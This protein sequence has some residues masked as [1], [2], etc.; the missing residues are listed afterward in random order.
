[1]LK[2]DAVPFE[3][4]PLISKFFKASS[5]GTDFNAD[6]I[7]YSLKSEHIFND[8]LRWEKINYG[9]EKCAAKYSDTS[10]KATKNA[11]EDLRNSKE[12]IEMELQR[13]AVML[14]NDGG[15]KVKNTI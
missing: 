7:L 6:D 2:L 10:N 9:Y 11:L 1:M 5:S 14:N 3:I 15:I 13:S 4:N 12:L 8:I